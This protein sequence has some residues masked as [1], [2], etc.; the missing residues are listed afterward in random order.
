MSYIVERLSELRRHLDHLREL[1]PSVRGPEV[2]EVDLSLHNDVLFSLLTVAQ[3]VIDVAGELSAR[4]GH[5]FE[6]YTTAVRNLTKIDG[7][8][9]EL[10]AD[11]AQLPGFRNI[12]V[13]EYVGLDY[14]LVV[15]ALDNLEPVEAFLAAVL[16]RLDE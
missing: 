6:D 5:R 10:V 1:R 11:L 13:H 7:F 16:V 12:L 2:L 9:Q 3:V 8:S 15:E 4:E 14:G